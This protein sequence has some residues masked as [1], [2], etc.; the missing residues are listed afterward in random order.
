LPSFFDLREKVPGIKNP[1]SPCKAGWPGN[2][3]ARVIF[4][5]ELY[6]R[7]AWQG[8]EAS[9]ASLDRTQRNRETT[10][11]YGRKYGR[12]DLERYSLRVTSRPFDHFDR[13]GSL[14][15]FLQD[16][17]SYCMAVTP[18]WILTRA[19]KEKPLAVVKQL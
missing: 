6:D 8:G 3:V 2:D 19:V 9:Q 17:A 11:F 7:T 16:E 1:L 10:A 4:C 14:L 12:R 15:C 18:S 5:D 13:D